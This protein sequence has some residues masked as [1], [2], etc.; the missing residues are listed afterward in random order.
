[1]ISALG[2]L[3]AFGAT[4]LEAANS[5]DGLNLGGAGLGCCLRSA[6]CAAYRPCEVTVVP[7]DRPVVSIALQQPHA[8]TA[9]KRLDATHSVRCQSIRI[10][11]ILALYL[12]GREQPRPCVRKLPARCAVPELIGPSSTSNV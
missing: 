1:V 5:P 3:R 7:T 9:E 10:N 6:A 2:G 11:Q 4:G 8:R 12:Q